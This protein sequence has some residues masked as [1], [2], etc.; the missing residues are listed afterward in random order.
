MASEVDPLAAL[1]KTGQGVYFNGGM[2]DDIDQL[3]VAPDVAFQRRDVEIAN[4]QS[5]AA[6]LFRPA[7]H[8]LD[9]VELLTEFRI[10]VPVGNVAASGHIDVFEPDAAVE[11]D[12]DMA[13]LAI[14]LPVVAVILPDRQA[15]E[16]RDTMVH[17]LAAQY[18][19]VVAQAPEHAF[20]SEEHT[21]ELQ[22]LM[23]NS[24]AVF[25]LKKKK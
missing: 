18:Q 21:S 4:Q 11:L 24:Y 25:C 8:P 5:G 13:R 19:M 17:A 23:R 14:V 10:L 16:D 2:A 1:L 20:R 6:T 15:A 9:I 22:S 7:R 3:L 12:T